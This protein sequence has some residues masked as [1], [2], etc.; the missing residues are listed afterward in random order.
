M[1][2]FDVV[3]ECR[4]VSMGQGQEVHARRLLQQSMAGVCYYYIVLLIYNYVFL[5]CSKIHLYIQ[6]KFIKR[7][8]FKCAEVVVCTGRGHCGLIG[9]RGLTL[10]HYT[11]GTASLTQSYRKQYC[12]LTCVGQDLFTYTSAIGVARA[13]QNIHRIVFTTFQQNQA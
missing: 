9:R 12:E 7:H 1:E 11:T 13:I 3:A 5:S 6:E 2:W 4:A 10:C 8:I